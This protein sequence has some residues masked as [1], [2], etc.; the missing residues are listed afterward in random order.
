MDDKTDVLNFAVFK[1][2]AQCIAPLQPILYWPKL[3]RTDYPREVGI[4]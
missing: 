3:P 4:Q 2:G 1:L